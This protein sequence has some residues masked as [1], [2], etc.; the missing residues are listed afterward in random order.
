MT[1]VVN[2]LAARNPPPPQIG[3]R[4]QPTSPV[5]SAD[6][7][8]FWD[9]KRNMCLGPGTEIRVPRKRF[10]RKTGPP[11]CSADFCLDFFAHLGW[12][13]ACTRIALRAIATITP[14]A[15]IACPPPPPSGV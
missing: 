15:R 12:G 5:C 4:I 7:W 3:G 14:T 11:V 9:N 6:L 13:V 2:W 1:A 10:C 8:G